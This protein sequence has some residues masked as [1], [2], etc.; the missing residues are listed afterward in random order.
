MVRDSLDEGYRKQEEKRRKLVALGKN[1]IYTP[2]YE[3]RFGELVRKGRLE[4][5]FYNHPSVTAE[6]DTHGLRDIW[7]IIR[8]FHL[9]LWLNRRWIEGRVQIFTTRA[10]ESRKNWS[11]GDIILRKFHYNKGDTIGV[12]AQW[13]AFLS[14]LKDFKRDHELK[15]DTMSICQYWSTASQRVHEWESVQMAH[16]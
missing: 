14:E 10:V 15:I 1:P 7:S 4:A 12:F 16:A 6:N 8:S 5:P 13:H 11:E 3:E 2:Y 9:R